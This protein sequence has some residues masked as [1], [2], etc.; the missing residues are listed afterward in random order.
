MIEYDKHDKCDKCDKCHSRAIIFQKYSGMRL[1]SVHFEEDVRRKI[2]ESIRETGIFARRARV[3]VALSGGRD[4]SVLLCVLKDL[5]SK[6]KDVELVAIMID[7][8]I[9]GYR[10]KTLGFAKALAERLE[11]PY[12]TKSFKDA[13]CV[14]ADEVASQERDQATCSFC[15]VMKRS[16][17][18][19]A[20]REL[21]ADALATGHNLDDEA[22]MIFQSYLKGDIDSLF[23]LRS[24]RSQPGL[25]HWIKPLRRIPEEEVA[26]YAMTHCPSSVD[27]GGCPHGKDAMRLEIKN[28]LNDFEARHPG[29]KYSLLR[30]LD[31][32]LDLQSDPAFLV[33]PCQRCGEPCDGAVCQSCRMLA[34]VVRGK[35]L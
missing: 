15:S 3:A 22:Q 5:F 12:V 7:E 28:M 27:S 13:F 14:T 31:R 19:K 4:S 35:S 21:N 26:L 6:R 17:L 18:A 34:R 32:I 1:C 23:R 2:R 29:T 10:P 8:G 16:L 11:V 25:V 9:E 33:T 20:A 30:S 24:Q